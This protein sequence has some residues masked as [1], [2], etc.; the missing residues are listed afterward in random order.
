M[1][2][3]EYKNFQSSLFLS[4]N[5]NI[6]KPNSATYKHKKSMYSINWQRLNLY[7]CLGNISVKCHISLNL[8]ILVIFWI[9]KNG[10]SNFLF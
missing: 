3:V 4:V 6:F 9:L 8:A 2:Y 10:I 5:N 7:D 1:F